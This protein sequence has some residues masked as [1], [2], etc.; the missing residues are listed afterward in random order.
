MTNSE[1]DNCP[2]KEYLIEQKPIKCRFCGSEINKF[3]KHIN[4]GFKGGFSYHFR[5]HCEKCKKTY[6]IKRTRE[7]FEKIKDDGWIK[8]KHLKSVEFQQEFT[9]KQKNLWDL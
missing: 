4:F 1:R 8:S 9:N 3:T 7:I 5:A 2:Q 6:N